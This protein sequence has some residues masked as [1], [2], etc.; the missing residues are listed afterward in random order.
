MK[1]RGVGIERIQRHLMLKDLLT[2]RRDGRQETNE[3]KPEKKTRKTTERRI[4][5]AKEKKGQRG[6][7]NAIYCSGGDADDHRGQKTVKAKI[8]RMRRN[9]AIRD[10]KKSDNQSSKRERKD[11]RRHLTFFFFISEETTQGQTKT[12]NKKARYSQVA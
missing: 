4:Y 1:K 12:E 10:T 7:Y 5:T 2:Q 6:Y 3:K 8:Y 9:S 11:S